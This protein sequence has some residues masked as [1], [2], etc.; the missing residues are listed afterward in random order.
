MATLTILALIFI[1]IMGYYYRNN[2]DRVHVYK[3]MSADS[4]F[5]VNGE[6]VTVNNNNYIY[7]YNTGYLGKNIING[8]SLKY[9][10]YYKDKIV[11]EK[12]ILDDYQNIIAKMP[13]NKFLNLVSVSTNLKK[14]INYN[15]KSPIFTI[16]IEVL[17]NDGE[18]T[19]FSVKLN[20]K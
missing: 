19:N 16:K 4:N 20:I 10:L 1:L 2:Y 8:N 18:S 17:D 3:L 14:S 11:F 6:I 15:D 12:N 13:I 7:I 9:S 5:L